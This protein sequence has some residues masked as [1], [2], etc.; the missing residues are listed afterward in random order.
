MA[1]Y[2]RLNT[3]DERDEKQSPKKEVYDIHDDEALE[4]E[5]QD[6]MNDLN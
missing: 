1:K 3:K 2:F 6:S 4:G 5:G